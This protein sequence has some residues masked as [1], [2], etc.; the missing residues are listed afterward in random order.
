MDG[1]GADAQDLS[2][3]RSLPKGSGFHCIE[4]RPHFLFLD[5]DSQL[6]LERDL[7]QKHMKA[8]ARNIDRITLD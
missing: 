8:F 3:I 5:K 1:L 7:G 4:I 6:G 2:H